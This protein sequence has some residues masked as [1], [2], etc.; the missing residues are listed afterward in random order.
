VI[1]AETINLKPLL[2]LIRYRIVIVDDDVTNRT[3]IE[4]ILR[5]QPDFDVY[6]VSHAQGALDYLS[7]H[8]AD[9]VLIDTTLPD[10]DGYALCGHI[11]AELRLAMLPIVLLA[12]SVAAADRG[13]ALESGAEDIIAKPF[14]RSELMLRLRN[15]LR[16]KSLQDQVSEVEHVMYSLT[17]L[18]EARDNYTNGHA[19]RVAGYI[20]KLGR[21]AGLADEEILMLRRAAYLKDI[22]KAGIPDDLLNSSTVW[23]SAE[24]ET[25]TDRLVIPPHGS[26]VS[27]LTPRLLP[28]IRHCHEHY[29]G[30]GYPD[31]MA[32]EQI[33]LGS[34]LLSIVDAFDAMTTERPFRN[35]LTGE[36]A[37][38]TLRRGGGSQWDPTL[39][40][41]FVGCIAGVDTLIR[42]PQK[43]SLLAA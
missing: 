12:G 6:S 18:I 5:S 7:G 4:A 43:P 3:L 36:E 23:T 8:V 15:L 34:R 20:E 10:A 19:E 26:K 21:A 39:V 29:D 33:P 37:I 32:G 35:A 42:P 28:I 41:L 30:S 27:V 16:L 40:E 13:R 17:T 14:Q 31:Q 9:A 24:R 1:C 22:G 2:S 25:M 11:K 38:T